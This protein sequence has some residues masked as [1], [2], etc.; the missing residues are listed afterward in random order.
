LAVAFDNG[1]FHREVAS[2]R[3]PD[4]LRLGGIIHTITDHWGPERIETG[5]WHGPSIRRDYYRIETDQGR[6]WWI[7]RNLGSVDRS[8]SRPLS[9]WMLH[10]QFD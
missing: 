7:F 6:W 2:T 5:W 9:R 1:P 8:R 3:L 4:R 10:G